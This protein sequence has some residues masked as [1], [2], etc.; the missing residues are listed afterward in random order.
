MEGAVVVSVRK[1]SRLL[2]RS[3]FLKTELVR[4]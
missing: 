4:V 1:I 3:D 2:G